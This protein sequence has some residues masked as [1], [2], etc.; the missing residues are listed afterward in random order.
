[1][2]PTDVSDLNCLTKRSKKERKKSSSLTY[3]SLYLVTKTPVRIS[4][5]PGGEVN[6]TMV[7]LIHSSLYWSTII[8]TIE[9]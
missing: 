6:V 1:M 7:R 3:L 8:V 9:H 2:Y 5:K 4:I